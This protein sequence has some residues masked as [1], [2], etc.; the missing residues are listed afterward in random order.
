MTFPNPFH[1]RKRCIFQRGSE[2]Q[3]E[4]RQAP[5]EVGHPQHSRGGHHSPGER[6]E[7]EEPKHL[8][9]G[10]QAVRGG[11]ALWRPL[12]QLRPHAPHASR[13]RV[14]AGSALHPHCSIVIAGTIFKFKTLLRRVISQPHKQ[15]NHCQ[16]RMDTSVIVSVQYNLLPGICRILP[17][18]P[19]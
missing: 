4:R 9:P 16:L 3:R 17:E 7:G 5:D 15:W 18:F 8:G 19:V 14:R 1:Q 6:G 10:H 2:R 11:D 12:C 13:G